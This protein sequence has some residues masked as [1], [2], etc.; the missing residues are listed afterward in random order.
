MEELYVEG[1]A[2]RGDPES[3][4]ASRKGRGVAAIE[5]TQAR[6]LSDPQPSPV[7]H[8]QRNYLLRQERRPSNVLRL[9][10]PET[11]DLQPG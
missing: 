8:H 2:T 9:G 3:C 11:L 1:L 6:V 5:H 4:V 7:I 10:H